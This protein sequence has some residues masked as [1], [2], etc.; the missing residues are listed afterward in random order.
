MDGWWSLEWG[1]C[2]LQLQLQ[3]WGKGGLVAG[4]AGRPGHL[5]PGHLGAWAVS[6]TL[7]CCTH[8]RGRK[9][10]PLSQ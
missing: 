5:A 6:G 7:R 1:S 3:V 4:H 9:P 10:P 2:R 8:E